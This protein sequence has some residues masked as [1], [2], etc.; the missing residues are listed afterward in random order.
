MTRPR[1]L[2]ADDHRIFVEGLR[3]MLCAEFE[4]LGIAENGREMIEM[5]K[6]LQP[7]II[8]A[9]IAMP[10][11]NGIEAFLQLRADMP[12][13][14]VIFLTMHAEIVFA[15]RALEAGAVGF[16]LKHSAFSEL[17]SAIRTAL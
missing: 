5:A 8:V 17:V 1:I 11:L 4:L 3:A 12:R 7:D 2:L 16:V 14:K 15:R 10:H 13:M 9:D 6:N